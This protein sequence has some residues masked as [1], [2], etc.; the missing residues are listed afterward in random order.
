VIHTLSR[1]WSPQL[2]NRRDID[3]YLPPSHGGA[4]RYP[5]VYMQDGQNLSDPTKAFAGTW[6]LNDVLQRLVDAGIEVIVVGVHNTERRLS[7][8]SPFPDARHGGGEADAYLSFVIDTVKPRIER[9]FRARRS[10]ADT[11]IVGSSMGGL[12]SL[13]AWFKRP[14]TFGHAGV[15]SPSLWFGRARLFDYLRSEPL[16]RV[17]RLYLDCGTAEGAATLRDVRALRS[18]LQGKRIRRNAFAYVE[19]RGGRHNEGSWGARIE[20]A[21]EFLLAR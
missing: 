18:T 9:L 7:E 17:G 5:V 1:V 11:A 19:D 3:V 20:G 13:Y 8:Y 2:R 15:M 4:R 16:P 21:L 6:G 10:P 14:D 12:L